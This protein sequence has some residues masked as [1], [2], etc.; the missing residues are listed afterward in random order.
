MLVTPDERR[1]MA[2]LLQFLKLGEMLARDCATAQAELAPDRRMSQFLHSQARQEG[3]HETIF[4]GA[5]KWMAPELKNAQQTFAPFTEYRN[6]VTRAFQNKD[7]LETILAEQ[8][9]FESLGEAI[10]Q[11]MEAGLQK[12]NAPFQ[13]LRRILLH[14]EAAHHGFG[15]RVLEQA[16]AQDHTSHEA[17]REKANPYLAISESIIM[18]LQDRLEEIDECPWDYLRAHREVLPSWLQPETQH[19]PQV[20]AKP[21]TPKVFS[22]AQATEIFFPEAV[23]VAS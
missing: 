18:T 10:L 19:I 20:Q 12:R 8:V 22:H 2:D 6:L 3:F 4:H 11:K 13:R 23:G 7:F 9:I 5:R 16:I 21:D 15:E 1:P 17:L 14:Q